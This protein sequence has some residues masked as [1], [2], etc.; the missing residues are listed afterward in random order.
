MSSLQTL[1][2]VEPEL[3]A[4]PADCL[5]GHGDSSFG[6]KIFDVSEADTESVEEPDCMID[7]FAWIAVS[8]IAGSGASHPVILAGMVSR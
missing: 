2:I 7:Y 8:V 5:V 6:E 4:P 1:G 3:R